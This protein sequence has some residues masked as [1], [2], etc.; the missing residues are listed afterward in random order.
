[1]TLASVNLARRRLKIR[2]PAAVSVELHNLAESEEALDRLM[3]VPPQLRHNHRT[4]DVAQL[5]RKTI[6]RDYREGWQDGS[7][8]RVRK[9]SDRIGQCAKGI[10]ARIS[11]W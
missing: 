11:T 5:W 2:Y 8:I 4:R 7:N 9:R 3:V 6:R 1:M 10:Q